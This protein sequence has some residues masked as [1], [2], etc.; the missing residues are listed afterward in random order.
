MRGMKTTKA[1]KAERRDRR[2]RRDARKRTKRER[3]LRLTPLGGSMDPA[4]MEQILADASGIDLEGPYA[5]LAPRLLPVV[6]RVWHPY[7]P[8]VELISLTLPPGIPVGFG[9]DIGVAF[10]HVTRQVLEHWDVDVPTVLAR[11]LDNLRDLI[12]AE[13]PVVQRF[14]HADLDIVAVQGQ[15]W[16]SALVLL[17]DVLAPLL[18]PEPRLL[19]APVRNTI[20]SLPEDIDLERAKELWWAL[21]DGAHDVLDVDPLLWTGTDIASIW[22]EEP[23]GLPN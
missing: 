13:P 19:L 22:E 18:G 16:G 9:I 10:T 6:K 23:L 8:E 21:A 1:D 15:G 20:L 14:R 7:P 11:S 12:R 2:A 4:L 17:P 5:E 3:D